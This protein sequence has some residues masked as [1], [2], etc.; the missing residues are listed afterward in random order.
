MK[1]LILLFAISMLIL[2]SCTETIYEEIIKTDTVFISKPQSLATTFITVRDTVVIRDTVEVKVIVRDTI[3]N[4]IHTTD[5]VYQV[6]TKDSVI[7]REVEKIVY[8]TDTVKVIVH[9]TVI[10]DVHHYDTIVRNVI[11]HDT[12]EVYVYDRTVIYLDTFVTVSY[13]RPV[14]SVPEDIIPHVEEFYSLCH[15]YG[16]NPPGGIM[17][18]QYVTDLPGENWSSNS[19]QISDNSQ[20]I[21]ELDQ[22]YPAALQ[23][24]GVFREMAKLQLNKKYT[25]IPDRIMNPVFSPQT[26][27]IKK[28]LDELFQ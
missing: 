7:I 23:R 11:V 8:H 18:I 21:I 27:I 28:H 9:D 20:M 16:L 26:T 10:N 2:G 22:K 6:I 12:V 24:A 14:W 3:V 13:M 15:Q 4:D 17:I 25:Q 1:T 19:F 5:T